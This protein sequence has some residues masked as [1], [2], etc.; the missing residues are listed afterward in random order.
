MSTEARKY[1]KN[2]QLTPRVCECQVVLGGEPRHGTTHLTVQ[3][4]AVLWCLADHHNL[5][6]GCCWP[7]VRTI[8]AQSSLSPRRIREILAALEC[9]G[10]IQR[11]C[12]LRQDGSQ[13]SNSYYFPGLGPYAPSPGGPASTPQQNPA[14][15]PDNRGGREDQWTTPDTDRDGHGAGAQGLNKEI[16]SIEERNEIGPPEAGGKLPPTPLKGGSV[17]TSRLTNAWA[18]VCCVLKSDLASTACSTRLS[19]DYDRCFRDTWQVGVIGER[20]VI[21]A[22]NSETLKAGLRKYEKRMKDILNKLFGSAVTGLDVMVDEV[23][24]EERNNS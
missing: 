2:L 11:R 21:M 18:Q 10:V 22:E 3:E 24:Q 17:N 1:V 7:S 16:K 6:K 9:R 8:A 12:R 4:R 23:G 13:T 5:G 15:T 19:D 20:L 14:F